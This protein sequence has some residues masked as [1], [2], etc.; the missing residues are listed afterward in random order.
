MMLGHPGFYSLMAEVDGQVVGSNF[1]DERSPIVGVGPITVAP[2]VQDDG[3]GRTLMDGA[4]VR[5]R[6]DIRSVIRTIALRVSQFDGDHD[7]Y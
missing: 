6:R 1:L 4:L 3:I 5:P 2:E 7:G